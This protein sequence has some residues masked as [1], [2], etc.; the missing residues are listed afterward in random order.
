MYKYYDEAMKICD[1]MLKNSSNKDKSKKVLKRNID[2]FFSQYM[3]FPNNESKPLNAITYYD[4]DTYLLNRPYSAVD[5]VN[6]YNALKKYFE[7]T[8]SQGITSEIISQV[9]KPI[10]SKKQKSL[11]LESDCN[12]LKQFIVNTDNDVSERLLL[13]LFLFTGLSRQYI[14]SLKNSSFLFENGVYKLEVYKEDEIHKLPLKAELQLVINQYLFSLDKTNLDAKI[15]SVDENY[16][17]S[18]VSNLTQRVVG[19]KYSPTQFSNTFISLALKN[20][21]YVWEVSNLVLEA[22]SSIAQHVVDNAEQLEKKQT[23]ILNSF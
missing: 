9:T 2:N 13:G 1:E 19:K 7:Y 18:V 8:Y 15:F 23:S 21:N 10:A 14:A 12:Q 16:L 4:I 17:S 11:I 22:V 3:A 20:G 6:V 5:K